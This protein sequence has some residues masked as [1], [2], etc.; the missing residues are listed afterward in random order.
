MTFDSNRV[1]IELCDVMQFDPSSSGM[2]HLHAAEIWLSDDE[3]KIT[4]RRKPDVR[5]VDNDRAAVLMQIALWLQ[6]APDDLGL[7]QMVDHV[8]AAGKVQ[9]DSS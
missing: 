8:R 3:G 6:H 5:L 9:G 4:R 2:T 7:S 1:R